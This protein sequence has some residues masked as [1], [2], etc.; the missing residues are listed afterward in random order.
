MSG[1]FNV[2][3]PYQLRILLHYF[4]CTDDPQ[5]IGAPIWDSTVKQFVADEMLIAHDDKDYPRFRIS[6]R[7][8]FYVRAIL[9]TPL[10][11]QR[12]EIPQ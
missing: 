6:P 1:E 4:C 8:E 2:V 12:W 10:P 9:A 5:E 3:S 11:V 7:G